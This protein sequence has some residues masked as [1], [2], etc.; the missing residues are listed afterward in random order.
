MSKEC[1]GKYHGSAIKYIN[2][3]EKYCLI[4]QQ[5]MALKK[6]KTKEN[7]GKVGAGFLTVVGAAIT[8]AKLFGGGKGGGNNQS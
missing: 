5:Q 6:Q 2:D 1:P 4:C 7:W 8:I 3:D